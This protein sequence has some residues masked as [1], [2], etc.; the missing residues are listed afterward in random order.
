MKPM[1]KKV[2]SLLATASIFASSAA[3]AVIDSPFKSYIGADAQ[4]RHMSFQKGYGDN[5]FKHDITQGNVFFGIPLTENFRIEAGY[6]A[7]PETSRTVYLSRGDISA[8]SPV[9]TTRQNTSTSRI[10]GPHL[11]LSAVMP[12]KN[13][14]DFKL[15]GSL[16]VAHLTMNLTRNT[17][18]FLLGGIKVL[19]SALGE[20][21]VTTFS[22]TK[23][24]LKL[25]LGFEY[26]ISKNWGFRTLAGWENT[27]KFQMASLVDGTGSV[28]PR[29]SMLY[30]MGV[31]LKL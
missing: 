16:G 19:P 24:I 5:L 27:K 14:P 12:I 13:N 6:E 4:I 21:G 25:S 11:S 17:N 3:V 29:N 7:N 22:Q 8:G 1:N 9:L 20:T 10:H 28:K 31:F 30:S 23:N 26:D 15:V 18:F 2:T